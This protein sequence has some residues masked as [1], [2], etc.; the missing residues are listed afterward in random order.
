MAEE[1]P[2][3]S[4]RL[5]MVAVLLA[6]ITV[7]LFAVALTL[8]LVALNARMHPEVRPRVVAPLPGPVYQVTDQTYNLAES[9][10][11][12][13]AALVLELNAEGKTTKQMA[14]LMEEVKKRDPQLRDIIIRTINGRSFGELNS[15]SGKTSLKG[16]LTKRLNAVLAMGELKQVLFVSFQMQ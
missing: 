10:R 11:Y 4:G 16:E 2:G 12:L 3:N 5:I 1:K 9:N 7:V 15:P 6:G 14:A 8:G 13:K